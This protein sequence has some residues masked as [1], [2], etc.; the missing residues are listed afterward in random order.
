MTRL[1]KA[2]HLERLRV[3]AGL[4]GKSKGPL[5]VVKL[6]SELIMG[7][8][9]SHHH[10]VNLDLCFYVFFTLSFQR[11]PRGFEFST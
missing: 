11:S 2:S 1:I 7:L 4:T 8:A 6:L 9:P 10:K 3:I 5:G